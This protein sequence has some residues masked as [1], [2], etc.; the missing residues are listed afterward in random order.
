MTTVIIRETQRRDHRGRFVRKMGPQPH[1]W[2][3]WSKKWGC[4]HRRSSTGGACGYTSDFRAAG[5]FPREKAAS[6]HDGY[7][8]EAFH[9]SEKI[10]EINRQIAV[11]RNDVVTL[12]HMLELASDRGLTP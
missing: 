6:Y 12:E 9:V 7:D 2:L 10:A 1:G 11:A 5:I 4:W 3:I 8:N